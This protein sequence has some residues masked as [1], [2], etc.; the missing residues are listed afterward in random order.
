[1]SLNK[2]GFDY[3]EIPPGFYDKI[4]FEE[5]GIRNFWHYQKFDVVLRALSPKK[6]GKILDIGC[7]GGSFLSMIG[8]EAFCHQVGIDIASEQIE[9]AKKYKTPFR[10][11]LKIDNI[12]SLVEKFGPQ[13]FDAITLIEV[14][15][16]LAAE[17]IKAI[18][19]V[20]EKI[21]KKDGEVII[22]TPNYL[23]AWPIIEKIIGKFLKPSYEE[24]HITKFNFL[25]FFTRLRKIYPDFDKNFRVEFK[26]TSHLLLFAL[27]GI[28]NKMA[29]SLSQAVVANK[30]KVPFG[31]LLVVKIK[32]I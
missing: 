8:Q 5:K 4:L 28:S 12:S 29:R 25:N 1:M 16:H 17:E 21:L 32:K 22:T 2:V 30:W 19:L 10:D 24:Q 7:S 6:S 18:F 31:A 15:E 20:I 11:F 13:Y 23:S 14:I 27:A 9:Y 3:S 26:T